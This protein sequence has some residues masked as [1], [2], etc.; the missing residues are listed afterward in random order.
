MSTRSVITVKDVQDQGDDQFHIYRHHDGYP[1]SVLP[2]LFKA[3]PFAWALPR[4]E[5]MDF[6]AAIIAGWKREGGGGVYMTK[7]YS[8]HGDLAWR[9]EVTRAKNNKHLVVKVFRECDGSTQRG[10]R[11]GWFEV[12]YGVLREAV[13]FGD[14]IEAAGTARKMVKVNPR[15]AQF[16]FDGAKAALAVEGIELRE[17]GDHTTLYVADNAGGHGY[18]A[19]D[20]LAEVFK[21]GRQMA[22]DRDA[23]ISAA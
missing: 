14:L 5:A 18:K 22:K 23:K 7:H 17:S 2:D 3:L 16:T 13:L 19:S 15:T 8:S 4:F 1:T 10:V 21:L 6:T 12:F 20:N 11:E 9:Y